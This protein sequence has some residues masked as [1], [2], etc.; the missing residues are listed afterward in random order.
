MTK[1]DSLLFLLAFC[2]VLCCGCSKKTPE[3]TPEPPKPQDGM[4]AL[5]VKGRQLMNSLG[6][7]V[8]LRGASFGAY[9]E[10]SRYYNAEG[11]KVLADAWGAN[12]M[13]LTVDPTDA[14]DATLSMVGEM[15]N[16]AYQNGLYVIVNCD[17][18]QAK[19]EEEEQFFLALL[20]QQGG[21]H[22]VIYEVGDAP[23]DASWSTVKPYTEELVDAIRTLA[24]TSV[25][26]VTPPASPQGIEEAAASPITQ[27]ENVMYALHI[28]AATDD[29]ALRE[30]AQV[31]SLPLFIAETMASDREGK[32]DLNK[33][34]YYEWMDWA[35][36]RRISWLASSLV[37]KYHKN[38]IYLPTAPKQGGIDD[39]YLSEWG[40]VMRDELKN[41]RYD[42]GI[43]SVK[44]KGNW[45]FEADNP[46]VF[47]VAVSVSKRAEG[48]LTM[49]LMSDITKQEQYTTEAPFAFDRKKSDVVKVSFESL[50]PGFYIAELLHRD[51]V[52]RKFNIGV[53][54]EEIISEPDAQ[55][56]FD[57]FWRETLLQLK[58][59][60]PA[61]EVQHIRRGTYRDL[62]IVTMRSWDN[63]VIR[64][65]LATPFDKTKK[66]PAHIGGMGYSAGAK[67]PNMWSDEPRIDLIVSV[68]GQGLNKPTNTYG[69]WLQYG[70][71][72]KETYYY[73]GAYCDMVRGVD[74][75]VQHDMVD[76]KRIFAEGTS[77]GGALT[78]AVAALDHRI[79]AA[80]PAV[81]FLGDF[82]DY[83]KIAY[84]PV[85]TMLMA[86]NKVGKT[87][88]ECYTVLSYFD[89]KNLASR[90]KCPVIMYSGLQDPTCPPH[91]NFAAYNQVT[92]KKAYYI[93][94]NGNH[95]VDYKAWGT[96]VSNFFSPHLK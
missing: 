6:A 69:D 7:T 56:D 54:P 5:H 72:S 33:E 8:V 70:I 18:D 47:E 12:V 81:P 92:T 76:K 51:E 61:Y 44:S 64:C 36:N 17:S 4:P 2:L 95:N 85:K 43:S 39:E 52:V 15:I 1:K 62:Y 58:G 80:A 31:S 93:S 9:A 46:A 13:R 73:R 79:T 10:G 40:K 38:A 42:L 27:S 49:R 28:A 24:P 22:N 71:A 21:A 41:W 94:Q 59:I 14:S 50:R 75:L 96:Q 19:A 23:S 84:W 78:Y 53:S 65:Y 86:A 88:A 57:D 37:D 87:E 55:P 11:V 74:F 26:L 20:G 90:I 16:A 63:E 83:G 25:I 77:Q 30:A 34:E 91:T 29:A 32:A 48:V 67:E 60:D 82:P 3:P 89:I 68:R 35:E 45:V 66:Y